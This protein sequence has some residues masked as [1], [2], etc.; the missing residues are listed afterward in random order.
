MKTEA[1]KPLIVF[2]LFIVFLTGFSIGQAQVF[3]DNTTRTISE[4]M[5]KNRQSD[6]FSGVILLAENGKIV[7]DKAYGYADRE[8]KKAMSTGTEFRLASVTKLFTLVSIMQLY[9][10]GKLSMD[11]KLG[12][13]LV[14]FS[15]DISEK[16][17]IR[18]LLT[19]SAGFGDYR[20]DQEYAKNPLS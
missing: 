1:F 8:N 7:F 19:M 11:D 15:A 17:T 13:Y 2:F 14:G 5:D 3:S 12:K 18:Q 9:D 4:M 10:E 16:V 6:L 20:Q